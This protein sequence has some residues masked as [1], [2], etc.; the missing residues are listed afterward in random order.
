MFEILDAK[1]EDVDKIYAL[2]DK[3][4]TYEKL[5][6]ESIKDYIENKTLIDYVKVLY[7]DGEFLGTIIYRI[8][9][10]AE[11]ITICVDEKA[12]KQQNAT[13]LMKLMFYTI[14][15][16]NIDLKEKCNDVEYKEKSCKK[17]MLEVRSK[18]DA[19]IKLYEKEKFSRID[20]RKDYYKDPIDDGVVMERKVV[21]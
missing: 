6:K 13:Y 16:Y 20:I 18:N 12:R 7:V 8:N 9:D 19:A 15:T 21:C 3:N 4:F 14:D 17:V 11:L 10:I 5:S 2:L 1:I